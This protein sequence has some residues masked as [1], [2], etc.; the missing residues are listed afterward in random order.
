MAKLMPEKKKKIKSQ[1]SLARHGSF[2]ISF[3]VFQTR[4]A[5]PYNQCFCIKIFGAKFIDGNLI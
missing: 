3:S 1:I 5:V 2:G 4:A